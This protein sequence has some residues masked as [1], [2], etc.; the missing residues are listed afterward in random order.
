MIDR[1]LLVLPALAA[2]AARNADAFTPASFGGRT[3]AN[4][5]RS[6][7]MVSTETE[8]SVEYDSAARLAYKDWCGK[9]NKEASDERFE[10]FKANY[11]A[12]TVANV[13][14]AKKARDEGSD[15]PKDLE[16]NEFGDMSEKEYL[17]MQ[18]GGNASPAEETPAAPSPMDSIMEATMAQS[19]ASSALAEAADAMAEEEEQLVEALGLDS[20]E[21][22]EEAIDSMQGIDSE[23]VEVDTSDVREVRVR[24]A[25][26]DWCKEYGK[27][28][29]EA[30]FPTFS[31]NFLAMEEYANENGREMVLNKYADC[32]EEEYRQLTNTAAPA[33]ELVVEAPV[34]K[35]PEAPKKAEEPKV[36]APKKE[37]PK[38]EAPKKEEPKGKQNAVFSILVL[39][40]EKAS[41]YSPFII[42]SS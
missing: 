9:F 35:K 36:E 33:P 29:D 12:I 4:S 15:R 31:S 28:P 32:T 5:V 38:A 18:S 25:Y 27:Q 11:E 19:D 39:C 7:S 41:P 2:L 34:E 23:G 10:T 26:M 40:C 37:E 3:A 14:A 21:E 8:V 42:I 24:A 1:R 16:L 22:L 6:F 17:E 13:S 30:R 20:I